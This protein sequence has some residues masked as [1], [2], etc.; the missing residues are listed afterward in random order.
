ME[1][2][3]YNQVDGELKIKIETEPVDSG[4]MRNLLKIIP[5]KELTI[6]REG[7][8]LNLNYYYKS[9]KRLLGEPLDGN[10]TAEIFL[11]STGHVVSIK[12]HCINTIFKV[13]SVNGRFLALV[14]EGEKFRE[15][16]LELFD[17]LYCAHRI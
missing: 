16:T 15:L 5:N 9:Q 17:C 4:I 10:N 13:Q 12:M 8:R 11:N 14:P 3:V 2:I 1:Q 7:L 6:P